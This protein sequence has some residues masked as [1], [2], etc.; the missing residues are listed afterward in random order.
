MLPP[1][2]ETPMTA[3][4]R[5]VQGIET[6]IRAVSHRYVIHAF[7]RVTV[8]RRYLSVPAVQASQ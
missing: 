6:A 2:P 8:T 7:Q 5:H 1:G 4:A 3:T